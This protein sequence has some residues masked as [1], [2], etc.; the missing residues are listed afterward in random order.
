MSDPSVEPEGLDLKDSQR[1]LIVRWGDGV[2]T[3]I[4]YRAL[5][6]A[7]RCAAC[8]DEM[9][10]K[11]ILDPASVPEDVGVREAEPTG[12]YGIR[13]TWT[14]GHSTGIYTWERIRALSSPEPSP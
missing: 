5:R 1:R 14:D 4:P 7:C 9:T 3:T 2:A 13:F 10:G 6:L 8:Q 12:L 11:P